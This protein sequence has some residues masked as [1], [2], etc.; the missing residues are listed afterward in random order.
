MSLFFILK[1]CEEGDQGDGLAN[2][3]TC[4]QAGL[5]EQGPWDPCGK[6][7]GKHPHELSSDLHVQAGMG[8]PNKIN[9][10]K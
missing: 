8:S 4:H 3:S 9:E 7:G 2:K 5:P 6:M 10:Q 1:T